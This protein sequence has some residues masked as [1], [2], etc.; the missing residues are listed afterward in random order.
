MSV[1]QCLIDE[2]ETDVR[3]IKRISCTIVPKVAGYDCPICF[4]KFSGFIGS[5]SSFTELSIGI[6]RIDVIYRE[7]IILQ[8]TYPFKKT[9]LVNC[10]LFIKVTEAF[11][12]YTVDL[13]SCFFAWLFF[14]VE[15]VAPK[16][17]FC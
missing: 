4:Q 17:L 3:F 14:P 5:I 12:H 1:F 2:E 9:K 16:K 8:Q 13:Q 11:S 7:Q 6:D 15:S 10:K